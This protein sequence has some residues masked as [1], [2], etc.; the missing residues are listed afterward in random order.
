M[1]SCVCRLGGEEANTDEILPSVSVN[2]PI[3]DS[4]VDALICPRVPKKTG[5]NAPALYFMSRIYMTRYDS[6]D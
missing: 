4:K 3:V 2:L 5:L 6:D 1:P